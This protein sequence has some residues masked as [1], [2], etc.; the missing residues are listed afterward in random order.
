MSHHPDHPTVQPAVPGI[1]PSLPKLR[2]DK[3]L[4]AV[5]LYKTRSQAITACRAGHVKVNG[6]S[7]KPSHDV[8][9]QEIITAKT[10]IITRTVKVIG[11]TEN[12]V[13]AK[14]VPN[15][16]ED[17]TPPSEYEK[18]R[19]INLVPWYLREKGMGRPTKKDRRLLDQFRAKPAEEDQP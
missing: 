16:L 18:P 6:E 4:W 13:G 12:R 7:V 5:R 3:W 2:I 9:L 10:G 1:V 19:E 14:I 11:F 15:F 8:R 17:L